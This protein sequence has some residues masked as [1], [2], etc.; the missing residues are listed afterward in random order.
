MMCQFHCTGSE[1]AAV[2]GVS[3]DTM[4]RRCQAEHKMNFAEYIK[5]KTLP[6]N[7]SIRR[8]QYI[9]ALAG[10]G[11]MLRFLGKNWLGQTDKFEQKTEIS[12]TLGPIIIPDNGRDV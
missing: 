10:D 3:E 7:V 6:G 9:L 2:I 12:G 4:T 5:R 1:I 8:K 11:Q